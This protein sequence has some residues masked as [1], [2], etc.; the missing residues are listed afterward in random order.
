MKSEKDFKKIEELKYSE[1]KG[2]IKKALDTKMPAIRL[3]PY[4]GDK[5]TVTYEYPELVALCPMTGILDLYNVK[6]KYIPDKHISELKS[7]RFYMLGFKDMRIGHE[8]LCYKIKSDFENQVK[9]KSLEV[10][11]DVA[12]R[13]G[14]KTTIQNE[15]KSK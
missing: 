8:H 4:L 2:I 3:M 13:G 6:I 10:I 12:V 1:V 5:E 7:L 9:P 11:L 14:F 15:S